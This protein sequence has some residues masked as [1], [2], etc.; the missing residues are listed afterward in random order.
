MVN[1][2]LSERVVATRWQHSIVPSGVL[3]IVMLISNQNK[4]LTH[5]RWLNL[6][7]TLLYKKLIFYV[8]RIS[9]YAVSN[10]LR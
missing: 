5:P 9:T 1:G 2:E 4:H 10:G 3:A 6:G 8:V 7:N